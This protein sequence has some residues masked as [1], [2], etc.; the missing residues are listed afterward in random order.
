MSYLQLRRFFWRFALPICVAVVAMQKTSR[1]VEWYKMPL[2]HIPFHLPHKEHLRCAYWSSSWVSS[3]SASASTEHLR[4]EAATFSSFCLFSSNRVALISF[5]ASLSRAPANPVLRS[6]CPPCLLTEK[7][8][9]AARSV[10]VRATFGPDRG[11]LPWGPRGCFC[12][13]CSLGLAGLPGM[14]SLQFCPQRHP[15]KPPPPPPRA[16][17]A[18]QKGSGSEAWGGWGWGVG[19]GGA[20]TRGESCR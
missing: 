5:Y 20:S 19:W 14:H 7:V 10:S 4:F 13:C 12:G 1:G 16:G 11:A 8:Q 17:A 6:R 18:G 15:I 3:S 9:F 2:T